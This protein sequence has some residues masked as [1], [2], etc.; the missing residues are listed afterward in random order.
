MENNLEQIKARC[1]YCGTDLGVEKGETKITCPTCNK[2][3]PV[4]MATKYY[5]SLTSN[6]AETKEAHG[7]NYRK[8]EYILD[9]IKGL[10]DIEEWEKAEDKFFEALDLS[11]TDYKVFMAMVA[12][13]TKNYTDLEDE[14]HKEYINKAIACADEE[15]KKEIV[16]EYKAY[17]YKRG[18]SEEELQ[19]YTEEENLVKKA[20]LEKNLKSMIPNYMA[21][22]KH[23]KIL[24]A[25]FPILIILGIGIVIPAIF[26]EDLSWLS[27]IGA[28]ITLVGYLLFRAWFTN[29]D[30]IKVF[31]CLLDLYDFVDVKDYNVQTKGV[32]Y[33]YMQKLANKFLDNSPVVSMLDDTGR[34]IDYVITMQDS[35]MNQFMLSSKYFSQFVD[36]DEEDK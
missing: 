31:N 12:I 7:E 14:E 13:K 35:E 33:A 26:I 15:A 20:K 9:E 17:Y 2:E 21:K 29:R 24:L 18:L 11:D 23:N 28:I 22:E 6:P 32:L 16:R 30:K 1:P 34:L 4:S 27:I 19:N 5:E 8:L 3:M 25:L 36:A 10:I